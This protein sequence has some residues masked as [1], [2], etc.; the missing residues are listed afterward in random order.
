MSCERANKK[1]KD[2]RGNRIFCWNLGLCQSQL[3]W[4]EKKEGLKTLLEIASSIS[5]NE[6]K[7]FFF[8]YH[9][10]WLSQRFCRLQILEY[11][12]LWNFRIEKKVRDFCTIK[13][14]YMQFSDF[15]YSLINYFNY[16]TIWKQWVLKQMRIL[17]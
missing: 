1:V 2:G 11:K 16:Y 6:F 17:I 9:S 8:P 14:T 10:S 12:P 15:D 3:E 4:Q 7:L 5:K 13:Q